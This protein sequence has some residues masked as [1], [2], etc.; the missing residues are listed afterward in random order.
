MFIFAHTGITLG[1]ARLLTRLQTDKTMGTWAAVGAPPGGV[2]G[3]DYRLILLGSMLPDLIDKPMGLLAPGL[4]LGTSRGIAHTLV[5]A[6]ILFVAGLFFYGVGRRG[7]LYVAL[8]SAGHLVLDRI[9]QLPK[10]LFW[11][12]YGFAFPAV[13][14]SGILAH[15]VAWCHTLWTNP[16]V[17]VP[18]IIGLAIILSFALRLRRRGGFVEFVKS[19]TVP[20]S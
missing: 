3:M 14:R 11:P 8:A 5:F 17:F 2:R 9:W 4:G 20:W 18:E 15:L 19:G 6:M 13:G 12:L 10:V 1:A 16:W 7:L